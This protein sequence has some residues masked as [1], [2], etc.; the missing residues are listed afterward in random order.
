MGIVGILGPPTGVSARLM[1]SAVEPGSPGSVDH[2]LVH[3]LDPC[4]SNDAETVRPG[5]GAPAKRRRRREPD[6]SAPLR[7]RREGL[8]ALGA[9]GTDDVLEVIMKSPLALLLLTAAACASG[10][11]DPTL[12]NKPMVPDEPISNPPP[13]PIST[14][15]EPIT[16]G[17]L[18]TTTPA[19][20]ANAAKPKCGWKTCEDQTIV[21][22]SPEQP[23]PGTYSIT[24]KGG[25]DT[26]TCTVVY[27][28]HHNAPTKCTG[29]L[30][31]EIVE[32]P[33]TF[34]FLKMKSAPEEVHVAIT[35][36]SDTVNRGKVL[37]M[38]TD[39]WPNGP[40]CGPICKDGALTIALE[41]GQPKPGPK[42]LIPE[43]SEPGMPGQ[44]PTAAR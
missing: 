25:E 24:L 3:W 12:L 40:Q 30:A 15:S 38:V 21:D 10:Q 9:S 34:P 43:F 7:E 39:L 1:S 13:D 27:P 26:T 8:D 44:G 18:P 5:R 35:Q 32:S 29:T 14:G 4:C 6:G 33:A 2:W 22:F 36:G 19:P 16:T 28:P 11:T 23:Q 31:V 41:D 37:P 17:A 20:A 42:V